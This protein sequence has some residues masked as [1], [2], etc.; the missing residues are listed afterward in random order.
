[1]ARRKKSTG[2]DVF[3]DLTAKIP[4]WLSLG[5]AAGGYFVLHKIATTPATPIVPG[6]M[7]DVMSGIFL[8]GL[9]TGGQYI[10]P[11]L[12]VCAAI[13]SLVRSTLTRSADKPES[14]QQTIPTAVREASKPSI[15]CPECGGAMV[16]RSAKRGANAGNM[17]WGCAS[18]PRCKG[19]RA[20]Q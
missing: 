18:Y 2:A 5:I 15:A 9:A 10:V 4:W 17:F 8:K 14:F 19:T 11:I 13:A 3:F 16:H 7:P 1:M 20:L 12:F 6:K